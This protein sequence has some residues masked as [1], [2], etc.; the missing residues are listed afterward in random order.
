MTNRLDFDLSSVENKYFPF[1]VE[2]TKEINASLCYF[3][4][5]EG[6]VLYFADNNLTLK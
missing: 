4:K 3:L 5:V 6:E 2:G 1:K